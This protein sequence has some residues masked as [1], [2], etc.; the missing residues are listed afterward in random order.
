MANLRLLCAD[1]RNNI[2]PFFFCAIVL[3]KG[4]LDHRRYPVHKYSRTDKCSIA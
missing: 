3:I 2:D 4:R 1:W